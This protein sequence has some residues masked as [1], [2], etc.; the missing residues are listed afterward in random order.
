M[1]ALET[2]SKII[3]ET[4]DTMRILIYK[5]APSL[6]ENLTLEDERI[7]MEPLLFAYFNEKS[8]FDFA[9]ETLTQL[10]Q[11]YFINPKPIQLENLYNAEGIAYV[12]NLGYYKREQE[13]TFKPLDKIKNST[14]E[15]LRCAPPLFP[16]I[17]NIP[18]E[19]KLFDQRLY[20]NNIEYLTNAFSFIKRYTPE[21]AA[22]IETCC[23]YFFIFNTSPENTNSFASR[24][25]LGT[26]FFNVYQKEYDEV[27]FVDDIA[28]QTGH[29]ILTCLFFNSKLIYKIDEQIEVESIVGQKDHRIINIL[30]HALYT[31]YTTIIC[32]DNCIKASCFDERQKREAIG[33][34]GFYL[35]K[36]KYDL[37]LL[38]KIEEHFLGINNIMHELGVSVVQSIKETYVKMNEKWGVTVAILNYQNQDYNFS[39]KKFIEKNRMDFNTQK[40][41]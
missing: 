2:I 36:Y 28:H 38:S 39:Y 11:G 21:H 41:I 6:L 9:D 33:R 27:F 40:S 34:I 13:S 26:A 35:L 29:V 15:L 3:S 23:R 31:Y 30:I 5:S 16:R 4:A 20:D 10:L 22:I 12:P 14:I 25:A 8:A 1:I 32:L 17:L 37:R 19:D 18:E 24:K 7:F